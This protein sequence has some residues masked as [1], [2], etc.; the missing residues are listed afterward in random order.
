MLKENRTKVGLMLLSVLFQKQVVFAEGYVST[1]VVRSLGGKPTEISSRADDGSTARKTVNGE[2]C[3]GRGFVGTTRALPPIP[4]PK[5]DQATFVIDGNPYTEGPN[6]SGFSINGKLYDKGSLFSGDFSDGKKYKDG[7]LFSGSDSTSQIRYVSGLRFN[8]EFNG[9]LY[10]NG[11]PLSGRGNNGKLYQLGSPFSGFGADG[12]HYAS[13]AL[14]P[15]E[16]KRRIS[17]A[18]VA[19]ALAQADCLA[20]LM[21]CPN[22]QNCIECTPWVDMAAYEPN[23]VATQR[24]LGNVPEKCDRLFIRNTLRALADNI[25]YFDKNMARILAPATT[26]W[27]GINAAEFKAVYNRCGQLNFRYPGCGTIQ[28]AAFIAANSEPGWVSA[29]PFVGYDYGRNSGVVGDPF[30]KGLMNEPMYNSALFNNFGTSYSN[31]QSSSGSG[32]LNGGSFSF[33]PSGGIDYTA[34]LPPFSQ[35]L[36]TST[37]VAPNA[38][39]NPYEQ[40]YLEWQN[41]MKQPGPFEYLLGKGGV[42]K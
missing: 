31:N 5:P 11:L 4:D 6:F 36:N 20:Q 10:Q 40:A 30:Q 35:S 17:D 13:G 16:G 29:G 14:C 8:G 41:G 1:T 37:P 2:A 24:M 9:L 7:E 12:Q 15:P 42:R 32:T 26:P 33:G 23:Y 19:N 39:S 22:G 21:D 27:G 34:G 25:D 28:Q 3:L 18:Q 38:G